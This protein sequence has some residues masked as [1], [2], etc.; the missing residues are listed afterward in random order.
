V[1]AFKLDLLVEFLF[2][3]FV[4][5]PVLLPI[6]HI[7]LRKY[8]RM[9]ISRLLLLRFLLLLVFPLTA[10]RHHQGTL[11]TLQIL[12]LMLNSPAG[13]C[14]HPISQLLPLLPLKILRQFELCPHKIDLLGE[15]IHNGP[16]KPPLHQPPHQHA[17][18]AAAEVHF[19]LFAVGLDE[20]AVG[21]VDFPEEVPVQFDLV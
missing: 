11:A 12:R 13:R 3:L 14:R 9:R 8:E 2:E 7:Q 16:P 20:E 19:V 6:Q 15:P 4:L 18:V 17:V 5:Q 10:R 1:G 21:V